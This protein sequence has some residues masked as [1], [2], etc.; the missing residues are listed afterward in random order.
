MHRV[1]VKQK[2]LG[3]GSTAVVPI[4]ATEVILRD[5]LKSTLQLKLRLHRT[6]C[7]KCIDRW[8]ML[9]YAVRHLVLQC[10]SLRLADVG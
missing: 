6:P 5:R 1:V 4:L 8:G 7:M 10:R 9:Q 3:L 2:G